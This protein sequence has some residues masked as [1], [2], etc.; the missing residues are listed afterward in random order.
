MSTLNLVVSFVFQLITIMFLVRFLMQAAQADFYNPVC[1]AVVK[2]TDP[3]CK[4]LRVII[5]SYKNLDFVS[6]IVAWLVA[7]L[8]FVITVMIV[9]GTYPPI[10][11]SFWYGFIKMLMVLFQFYWFT[12]FITIIASFLVQGAYHPVLLLLQQLLDPLLN[13]L[14][15]IV[16]NMGP[17][18][19]SPLVLFLIIMIIQNLLAQAAP[20]L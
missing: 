7:T 4:P 15:K 17:L 12:L 3:I 18:D 2:G 9:M 20:G 19:L 11:L 16:P 8:G 5:P 13:P 14:R 1:Q 6:I 10:V